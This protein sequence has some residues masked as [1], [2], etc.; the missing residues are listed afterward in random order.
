MHAKNHSTSVLYLNSFSM[1]VCVAG[2]V[3][4]HV[5]ICVCEDQ[6]SSLIVPYIIFEVRSI[7]ESGITYS[8][9]RVTS[10]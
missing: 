5:S 6:R 1:C 4:K 10:K 3:L 8:W 2:K 7:T 9:A